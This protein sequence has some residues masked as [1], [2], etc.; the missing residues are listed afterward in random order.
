MLSH[1]VC[2]M[3][4]MWVCMRNASHIQMI[5]NLNICRDVRKMQKPWYV[6]NLSF[7]CLSYLLVWWSGGYRLCW[8]FALACKKGYCHMGTNMQKLSHNIHII[9]QTISQILEPN[10]SWR[11]LNY[12]MTGHLEIGAS[13]LRNALY[14]QSLPQCWSL[15]AV[16]A[17]YKYFLE[18]SFESMR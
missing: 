17:G 1:C 14:N 5:H 12:F 4:V 9:K 3:I 11:N 10:P 15:V 8:L 16:P 2:F 18:N 6:S 7:S 13:S